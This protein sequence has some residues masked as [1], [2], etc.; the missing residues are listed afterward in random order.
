L[1]AAAF[2]GA[3]LGAALGFAF[4]IKTLA[5]VCSERMLGKGADIVVWV[6]GKV[7]RKR[8]AAMRLDEEKWV[9][10]RKQTCTQ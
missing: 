6:R 4:C 10:R 5:Q 9:G 8:E 7:Q 2:L 1:G 3:A